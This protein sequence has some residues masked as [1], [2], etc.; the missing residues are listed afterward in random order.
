MGIPRRSFE[1]GSSYRYGFNGKENDNDVKGEGNQ[2][3]Y[4]MRISDPR[5]GKFLSVDPIT[6]KYPKLTPY[7][8]ASSPI[9]GV[10]QDGLKYVFY[11]MIRD[12][13]TSEFKIV[14]TGE[15]DYGNWALNLAHKT[16]GWTPNYFKTPVLEYLDGKHYLFSSEEDVMS[17]KPGD[18]RL[19][20]D[21]TYTLEGIGALY[22][23]TDALG[24]VLVGSLV[25]KAP[26][27]KSSP[28]RGRGSDLEKQN[29]SAAQQYE[30]TIPGSSSD[31]A[32]RK[33]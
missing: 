4:G 26:S 31:V 28:N 9:S 24:G 22:N 5:L 23:V 12:D 19:N 13:A 10:D 29:G 6:A 2:Q 3:D 25:K 14:K 1:A 33:K 27:E 8:F 7:Q 30:N 15:M 11:K 21:K 17:L 20:P 18:A 32:N 16:T